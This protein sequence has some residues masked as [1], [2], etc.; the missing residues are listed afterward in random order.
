MLQIVLSMTV[1]QLK[2][3]IPGDT[4]SHD[5][6]FEVIGNDTIDGKV[7]AVMI[8]PR[9]TIFEYSM[10]ADA[11]KIRSGPIDG[12]SGGIVSVDGLRI[13]NSNNVAFFIDLTVDSNS[14]LIATNPTGLTYNITSGHFH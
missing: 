6:I 12:S 7:H 8:N 2:A 10:L 3:L 5:G 14:D 11:N 13:T 4:I 9:A 1:D